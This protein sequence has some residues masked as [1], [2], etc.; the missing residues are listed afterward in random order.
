[1]RPGS[2][3]TVGRNAIFETGDKALLRSLAISRKQK[4]EPI[5]RVHLFCE[6]LAKVFCACVPTRLSSFDSICLPAVHGV[7]S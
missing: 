3:D 2:E 7:V 4:R 1:M 5:Q 6:E